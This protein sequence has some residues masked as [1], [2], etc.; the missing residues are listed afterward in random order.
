MRAKSCP[1][2]GSQLSKEPKQLQC[3]HVKELR[4]LV[5]YHNY[6]RD[7]KQSSSIKAMEEF[8]IIKEL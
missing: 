4:L 8:L 3:E 5:D 7:T 6:L 1:I 2:C